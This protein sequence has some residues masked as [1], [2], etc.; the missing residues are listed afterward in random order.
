MATAIS[1]VL[2]CHIVFLLQNMICTSNLAL[3]LGLQYHEMTLGSGV[4]TMHPGWV[5]PVSYLLGGVT[6]TGNIF[7]LGVCIQSNLLYTRVN[8]RPLARHVDTH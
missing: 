2:R 1:M 5:G 8:S 4:Q 6:L 7:V 3:F